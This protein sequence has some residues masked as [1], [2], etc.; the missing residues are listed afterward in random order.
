[1]QVDDVVA[2]IAWVVLEPDRNRYLSKRAVEDTG[3][4]DV[5]DKFIKN[6][7]KTLGLSERSFGRR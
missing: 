6:Y 2:A 4:G 3:L 1:M 5:E 7:R